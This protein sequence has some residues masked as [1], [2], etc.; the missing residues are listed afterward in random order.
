VAS[1]SVS[2]STTVN[3]LRFGGRSLRLSILI[4]TSLAVIIRIIIIIKRLLSKCQSQLV[5][6]C[7]IVI[8][9][10]FK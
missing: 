3:A 5:A 8:K 4:F 9:I 2:T 7:Y 10:L 6:Q 1:L